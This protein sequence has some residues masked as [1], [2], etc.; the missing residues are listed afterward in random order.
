MLPTSHVS[1]K[2]GKNFAKLRRAIQATLNGYARRSL[3][4][5]ASLGT[6]I[7]GFTG[8]QTVHNGFEA[9]TNNGAWNDTVVVL[10]NRSMARKAWLRRKP[11]FCEQKYLS[12]FEAGFRAGYESV[13][14]GDDG[15]TP[16]FAPQ[17]YWSW[18]FQSAEGQS[19]TAAWFSGFPH[20]ARA[21]EE[22]GVNNWTQLQMSSGLQS[23][24]QETGMFEHEGALYPIPATPTG[25]GMNGTQTPANE[26][27][28]L[29]AE[30]LRSL[31]P[32]AQIIPNPADGLPIGG[33]QPAPM[34]Q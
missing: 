5:A 30:V 23:Q 19:R 18:E 1:K 22:D 28:L 33:P 3:L 2:C 17:E 14:D 6:V 34:P 20:G 13:A 4:A 27:L 29:P 24:Y 21:A 32:G 10:R 8:C 9:I 25:S 15:C 11:H 31:P 7:G 12:D 26:E 16:N